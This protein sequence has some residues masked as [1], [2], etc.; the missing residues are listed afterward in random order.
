[1]TPPRP[2]VDPGSGRRTDGGPDLDHL[3]WLA[4]LQE[5]F[6]ADVAGADPA[7]PVPACGE[8]RVRD[9]VEHL[10]YIHHWAAGQ[11]CRVPE[12]SL[13]DGPYDLVPYYAAHAA[14]VRETLAEL[15]PDAESWTLVGTGP[16]SF[17]RRR[18]VH[19]T[20]VHLHDLRAARTGSG[21]DVATLAPIDVPAELWA[22][23]VDEVVHM[24]VPRQVR[25]GRAEPPAAP[26]RLEASDLGWSW[27]LDGTT[28]DGGGTGPDPVVTVRAPS[29][30]LTL[31][32][33]RR[34]TPD[35]AGVELAGDAAV[36][37][38][39]LATALVP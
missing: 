19:E 34:L 3:S 12:T 16:A 23:S 4:R 14:E 22:D 1:M 10:G 17:W 25:L 15:G 11:A 2:A 8:W 33:W 38:A 18:Q 26:V 32:L 6:A 27:T 36:L 31:L 35:E 13:G 20:L 30:E 24:F 37:D 28:R 21:P 5:A 7:A 29:R 39:L 9:L